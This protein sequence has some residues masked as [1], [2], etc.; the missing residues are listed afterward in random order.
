M[1]SDAFNPPLERKQALIDFCALEV[2]SALRRLL[3]NMNWAMF[4]KSEVKLIEEEAWLIWNA[5]NNPDEV[6]KKLG[7]KAITK[8]PYS[9]PSHY[10][11][12]SLST[13]QLAAYFG[14]HRAVWWLLYTMYRVYGWNR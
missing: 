4:S 3:K 13:L 1:L 9:L 11:I 12:E 6:L 2:E 14:Y 8:E 5:A 7:E 10:K